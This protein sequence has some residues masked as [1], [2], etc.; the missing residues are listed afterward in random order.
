[1]RKSSNRTKGR[2]L[3][4]A[5]CLGILL[6]GLPGCKNSTT[7]DG[8][9]EARLRINNNCGISVDVYMDGVFQ[10][11][12][13]YKEYYYIE[14]VALG[15]H[16][17]EAKKKGT[18]T[19][20]KSVSA[21]ITEKQDYTWTINSQA[22]MTVTNNYGETVSLYGDDEYYEDLDSQVSA[23]FPEI[24]YGEHHFE[25]KRPNQTEVLKEIT[26]EILGDNNY[27]WTITK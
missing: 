14:D 6:L 18:E 10:F 8:N 24:P 27:T 13:D 23:S 26:I 19:L 9:E 25:A 22:V 17:L 3:S 16:V 5:A 4:I 15:T 12:L 11:F 7:P 21:D 20:L 2:T 1:M